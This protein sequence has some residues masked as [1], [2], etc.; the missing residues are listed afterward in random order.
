MSEPSTGDPLIP[1]IYVDS[2]D[3]GGKGLLSP[4]K[5]LSSRIGSVDAGQLADNLSAVCRKL[6]NVFHAA[7]HASDG[8]E[9]DSFEVTV[10]VTARGEVWLVGSASGELH[11]GVKLVFRRALEEPRK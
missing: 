6:T 8:Y 2:A 7:Q 5:T 1:I 3:A 10:D 9:L 11:G 4:V